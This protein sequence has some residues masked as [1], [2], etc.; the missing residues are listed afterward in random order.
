MLTAA[1][2]VIAAAAH[3]AKPFLDQKLGRDTAGPGSF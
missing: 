3:I 2:V 1:M